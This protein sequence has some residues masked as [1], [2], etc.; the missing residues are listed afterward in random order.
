MLEPARA[1]LVALSAALGSRDPG[2]LDEA[3]ARAA[4]CAPHARV[5]EVLLQS[6]L[7]VGFPDA[8]NAVARWRA[9]APGAPA[10]LGE[11]PGEWPERGARVCARVYGSSYAALRR[12]VAGLHPELD[13]WMV[14]GGYGR[15]LGRPGLDLATRELCV[16]ALLAVWGAPPQLHSHLRGALNAGAAPAEVDEAVETACGLLDAGAAAGVREL[17]RQVRERAAGRQ[18]PQATRE[19]CSSI[20]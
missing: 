10:P 5:E 9:L 18:D 2:R 4:A 15:V 7:F 19:P 20:S 6:H 16:A 17:W 3:L 13:E 14:T 1:A 12:N 8:L 11:A